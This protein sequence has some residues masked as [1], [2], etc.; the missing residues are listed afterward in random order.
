LFPLSFGSAE[1]EA[2]GKTCVLWHG[3]VAAGMSVLQRSALVVLL[4]DRKRR[5]GQQQQSSGILFQELIF[6]LFSFLTQSERVFV[7]TDCASNDMQM[8]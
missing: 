5:V 2:D 7:G 3:P 8:S 4:V 6:S 1:A